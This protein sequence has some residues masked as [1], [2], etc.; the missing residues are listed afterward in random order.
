VIV[1]TSIGTRTAWELV[2]VAGACVDAG[3]PVL[4]VLVVSPVHATGAVED[5]PPAE[6]EPA[7]QLN[8]S[9]LNG[10]HLNGTMTAGSA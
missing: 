8:G 7:A 6:S 4:G 1:V 2:G 3:H 10:S 5:P 9:H